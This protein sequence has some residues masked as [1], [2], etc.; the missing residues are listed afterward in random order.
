[1]YT[2]EFYLLF[3]AQCPEMVS[4]MENTENSSDREPYQHIRQA[5]K[6]EPVA[7]RAVAAQ[8]H[9]LRQLDNK[10]FLIMKESGSSCC[11]AFL[12]VRSILVVRS[13]RFSGS[14]EYEPQREHSCKQCEQ[15]QKRQELARPAFRFNACDW[16]LQFL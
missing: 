8:Q 4:K 6:N 5:G 11:P 3:H 2:S 15:D 14:F 7:G 16:Y 10:L 1:M 12:P 9:K 13:L